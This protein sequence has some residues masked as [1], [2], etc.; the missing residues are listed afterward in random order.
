LPTK[1]SAIATVGYTEPSL[2][3]LL[4]RNLLLLG[5]SEA[6]LFLIE[7]PGG[8]AIIEHR[9]RDA[10]LKAAGQLGVRLAP[11]VQLSGINI[12]KGQNVIIFLYSAEMFDG[13]ASKE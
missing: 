1:P 7:A 8:L 6:A 9:Q 11:P 5:A 12:S 4:G 10:F 2:V 13:N 3:F